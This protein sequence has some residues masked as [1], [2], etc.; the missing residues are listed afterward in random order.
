MSDKLEEGRSRLEEKVQSATSE[1]AQANEEL[2][3]LDRLKTD[4]LAT[5]SHELRSPLTSIRGGSTICV[6][7]RPRP[8]GR[9]ISI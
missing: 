5:M 7:R 9:T 2:K 8:T 1:L 3:T 6:G 4:F